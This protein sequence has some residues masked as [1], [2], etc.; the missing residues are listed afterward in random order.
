MTK[1][2]VWRD[3]M[4]GKFQMWVPLQMLSSR[5]EIPAPHGAPQSIVMPGCPHS[6]RPL[7]ARLQGPGS[8]LRASGGETLDHF[9]ITSEIY[10]LFWA[11]IHTFPGVFFEEAYESSGQARNRK[12]CFCLLC[13]GWV[14]W[15]SLTQCFTKSAYQDLI[16][17]HSNLLHDLLLKLKA[18]AVHCNF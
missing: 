17:T 18:E 11:F 8:A 3:C 1:S 2:V 10:M 6:T 14:G 13:L 15:L 7:W 9:A 4:R 12:S 16:I 5:L